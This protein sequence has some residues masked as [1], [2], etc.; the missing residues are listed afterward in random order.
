MPIQFGT[1]G[2]R[3][4]ANRVLTTEVCVAIGRATAD[5]L[6][7]E[8]P[9]LIGRDTRQS[10]TLIEF[11][12]TAGLCSMGANVESAGSIPTPGLAFL[13][14]SRQVPGVMVSASHNPYPDN[15]IKL[16]GANGE[17][18][19]TETEHRI[20]T[21]ANGFL[22]GLSIEFPVNGEVGVASRIAGSV[23]RYVVDRMH[24]IDGDLSGLRMVLDCANG[25]QYGAAP[26]TMKELNASVEVIN[27]QPNGRNINDHCGSTD[28]SQLQVEVVAHS[29]D[30]GFA[31]DGDGDRVIAVDETGAIVNGDHLLA[32]AAIELRERNALHNGTVVI[33]VMAN[34]GLRDALTEAGINFI[35]TPVG[36]P[37]VWRAMKKSGAVL[38]G[39]QSGHII[40]GDRATTGDGLLTAIIISDVMKRSGKSLS[41]LAK[42]VQAYPQ[43]LRNVEVRNPQA[44]LKDE[45]LNSAIKAAQSALGDSGRVLVRASGTQPIIRVMVEAKNADEAMHHAD[46]LSEKVSEVSAER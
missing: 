32:I 37:Y 11:G 40:F 35:E 2:V 23:D 27:A 4:V 3:G 14:A 15:G 20:E 17:K 38:G 7:I 12:V 13:C 31:F 18:L 30:V 24:S 39:E 46:T 36:D 21:R 9:V 10:G 1:D 26:R 34:L 6:G 5:I 8:V 29:A 25:A 45:T 16:F 19:D 43:E 41:E 44:V 28:P 42:V 22:N 33:T